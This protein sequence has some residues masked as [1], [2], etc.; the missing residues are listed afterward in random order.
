M[1]WLLGFRQPVLYA[2]TY[3]CRTMEAV[4]RYVL[5]MCLAFRT[6]LRILNQSALH[7]MIN[8]R[9]PYGP[10]ANTQRGPMSTHVKTAG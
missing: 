10:L 7:T 3:V 6:I 1:G 4:G 5:L 9:L 8:Y 2:C